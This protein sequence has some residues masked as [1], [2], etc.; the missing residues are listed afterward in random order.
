MQKIAVLLQISALIA[1]SAFSGAFLFIALVMVKFWQSLAPEDFLNWMTNDLYLMPKIMVPLNMVSLVLAI[2]A[3]TTSWK[4][5]PNRRL[6][7][8]LGLASILFCTITF[9]IYFA[10]A[11]AE[12][13]NQCI[14]LSTVTFK[15]STWATW[16]WVRTALAI[17]AVLCFAWNLLLKEPNYQNPVVKM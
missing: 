9:P 3:I 7:L 17:L 6:P 13:V 8:S 1:L 15:L 5:F 16:H 2:A 10:S 14:E 11:N 4:A 12:F